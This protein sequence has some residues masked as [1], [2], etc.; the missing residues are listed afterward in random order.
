MPWGTSIPQAGIKRFSLDLSASA[1]LDLPR[2]V[3]IGSQSAGKSSLVEGVSG[4]CVPRDAGTCTRCPMECVMHSTSGPWRC[5]I[6]LR[7]EGGTT[8]TFSPEVTDRASVE[9]WL[10]RAQVASL[11]PHRSPSAFTAMSRDELKATYDSDARM[12]K[13]TNNVV[14]LDLH[15]PD[16]TDLSFVDLPGLI[17]NESQEA[18]D[19]VKNMVVSYIDRPNTLILVAMPIT[20]DVE[21]Q[22]AARLAREADPEGL[23]TIGVVTKPDCLPSG[24]IDSHRRWKDIFLGRA[25][26][27]NHGYYCVRLPDDSERA[28]QASR[29]DSA[30]IAS[31]FFRTTEP[32]KDGDMNQ[33]RF[34]IPNLVT[35]VSRL[36]VEL[37]E[38]SLPLLKQQVQDLL[39][40]C[41]ED[42]ND[43]PSIITRDPQSEVFIRVNNFSREFAESIDARSHKNY[44][45]GSRALY[46]QLKLDIRATTPDFRPFPNYI[47]HPIPSYQCDE[48]EL[49]SKARPIDLTEVRDVIKKSTGWELPGHVPYE[50]TKHLIERHVRLWHGPAMRCFSNVFRMLNIFMDDLQAEH[51]SRFRMLHEHV[52]GVATREMELQKKNTLAMLEQ[53]LACESA[54]IWTQNIHY[55][56]ATS[57]KWHTAY[58]QQWY[59]AYPLMRPD[60]DSSSYTAGRHRPPPPPPP[61]PESYADELQV[62]ANVRAYFQVAYK[63]IID[64]VPLAIER[65]LNRALSVSLSD[66]LVQ[67]LFEGPDMVNRMR[68]LVSEDPAIEQRR[69]EL[70][71]RKGQLD[72]IRTRLE[73]FGRD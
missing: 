42:I 62:M 71:R 67:S 44:V 59:L 63:R 45:Q 47:A 64:A 61:P 21:N 38:R 49:A 46:E 40:R 66:A 39:D 58:V 14:C 72:E 11:C 56:K 69:A 23:R 73:E 7:Q 9:L 2:V 53:L 16:A 6:S 13:F 5:S 4:I 30:S 32:W 15:D 68:N 52:R 54:P 12:L 48:D 20:D 31:Q 19:L 27:L 26:H 10:R 51:F 41:L 50:A 33:G 3:V 8:S 57:K 55:Y 34:G 17:Q 36:L 60:N 65:D 24:A 18:I 43:L 28:R 22:Q 70:A 25:H 29:A 37:I 1:L 35:D